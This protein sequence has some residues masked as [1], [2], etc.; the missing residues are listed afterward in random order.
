MQVGQQ[1]RS[2]GTFGKAPKKIGGAVVVRLFFFYFQARVVQ[3]VG[4]GLCLLPVP[5]NLHKARCCSPPATIRASH[6]SNITTALQHRFM[7]CH[8]RN[9][10]Q[11]NE[12]SICCVLPFFIL[13]LRWQPVCSWGSPAARRLWPTRLG[14][15]APAAAAAATVARKARRTANPRV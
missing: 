6:P 4:L 15:S 5:I 7:I 11:S 14:S 10:A 13:L 12:P 1:L 9:A 2:T 8:H 3:L